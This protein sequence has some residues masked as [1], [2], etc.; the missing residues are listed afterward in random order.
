[1][2]ESV[3]GSFNYTIHLINALTLLA[4]FFSAVRGTRR[5]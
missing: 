5:D 2:P 1:M 3:I 4:V